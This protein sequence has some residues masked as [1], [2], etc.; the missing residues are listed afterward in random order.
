MHFFPA[1]FAGFAF[2][3]IIICALVYAEIIPM[4]LANLFSRNIYREYL[5]PS[6][7]EQE[8]LKVAKVASFF[9]K[10]GALVFILTYYK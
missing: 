5:N 2:A 10:C 1:W 7:N 9:V 8:E 4:A 3:A 6:C